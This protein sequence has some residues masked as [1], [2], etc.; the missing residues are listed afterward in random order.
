MVAGGANLAALYVTS[1]QAGAGKTAVCAGLARHLKNTGKK[2]GYFKPLVAD[3]KEKA[4]VD[5]DAEFMKKILALKEPAAD[6]CPVIAREGLAEKIKPAYDKV[7]KDKD[8]VIVEGVWRIRPGA[9]PVEAASEVAKVLEAKV[10]AVEPYSQELDGAKLAAKYRGFGESLLGIVVNK[11][12]ARR[13][14]MVSE[15]LSSEV[16]VL[17]LL[18]EDRNLLGLTVGEIAEKIEGEILND[19]G[20]SGEVVENLM[21]G[22]MVVDAGPFYYGRKNNKAAIL[23]GDRPDMQ[24]AALETSTRCLVLSGGVEPTYQVR[25]SAKDKGI[26]IILTQSDT[27]SIVNTIELALGRPRLN[28]EKKLPRLLEIMEEHFNFKPVEQGLQ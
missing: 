6:L 9:K 17:G 1:L 4:A 25:T 19:V 15:C 12:P 13:L 26:P 23:R 20:K 18:P 2:V 16:V 5:S 7:A 24:L 21:L 28:Q 8:V 3:I 14:E 11:V 22:A 10:V 27:V